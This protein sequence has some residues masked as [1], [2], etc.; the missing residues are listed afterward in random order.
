MLIENIPTID[1]IQ[2]YPLSYILGDLFNQKCILQKDSAVILI[3]CLEAKICEK[4][5][6]AILKLSCKK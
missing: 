2:V 5:S 4:L 3:L 1:L 6:H